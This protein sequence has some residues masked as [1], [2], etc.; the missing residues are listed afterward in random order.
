MA[1]RFMAVPRPQKRSLHYRLYGNQLFSV[2]LTNQNL[3]LKS[4]ENFDLCIRGFRYAK[5][6]TSAFT[7]ITDLSRT[8]GQVRLVP[9]RRHAHLEMM[10]SRQRGAQIKRRP[11]AASQSKSVDSRL[12]WLSAL[13]LGHSRTYF[14]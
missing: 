5:A 7:R 1:T 6:L 12:Q 3:S 10:G 2:Y 4:R 8:L 11:K 14:S 9:M 13:L